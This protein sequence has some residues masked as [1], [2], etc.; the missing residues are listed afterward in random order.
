M[1]GLIPRRTDDPSVAA[2]LMAADGAAVLTRRGIDAAAAGAVAGDVLGDLLAR[3]DAAAVREGG[4]GDRGLIP[5]EASM[6]VH[7]DGFAYGD[8]HPDGLFLLCAQ[9]GT[10]GG[11]SVLVDGHA[12]LDQVAAEDPELHRFVHE[13]PVDLTEPDM[14]PACSPIVLT[15]PSG[16]TA[17]R[18]TPYMA[19]DPEA[20]D[21][22]ADRALIDR[23]TERV[24]E[25]DA[26]APRFTLEPGE[27][28]CIDNY[29][30]LHG[31]GPFTG[32]RMLWRIWA[33]TPRSNGVP[34][35]PL[36]SDSRYASIA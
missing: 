17:V 35:G 15:L 27:A 34:T 36:H 14:R 30:M 33:W 20:A 2:A 24:A 11:A 3:P 25:A 26:A 6:P 23:W 10:S 32:E 12:L 29:R 21:P 5:P 4:E 28:L 31:R 22:E 13:V 9:Q 1:A 18:R 16:R 7:V 8:H 19:P